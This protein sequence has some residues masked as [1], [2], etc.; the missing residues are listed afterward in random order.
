MLTKDQALH[1]LAHHADLAEI[2]ELA[3]V[4]TEVLIDL[5]LTTTDPAWRVPDF[6]LLSTIAVHI[7]G[8]D[9]SHPQLRTA[10]HAEVLLAF[11]DWLLPDEIMADMQA[12]S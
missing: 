5:A 11:V 8:P 6:T 10:R 9:A 3:P 7:A 1:S 4:Q 12:A 2:Y